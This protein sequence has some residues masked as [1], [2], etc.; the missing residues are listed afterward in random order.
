MPSQPP[1]N[2]RNVDDPERWICFGC[3]GPCG[4]GN[5]ISMSGDANNASTRYELCFGCYGK[6]DIRDRV[7]INMLLRSREQGGL[8]LTEWL[9]GFTQLL[10]DSSDEVKRMTFLDYIRGEAREGEQ[11]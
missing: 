1:P 5:G 3:G 8:G 10:V 7:A 4:S 9:A 6:L 11:N 2:I